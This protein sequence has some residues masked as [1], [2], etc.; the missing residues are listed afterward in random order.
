[1][2]SPSQ[3]PPRPIWS[4]I[5]AYPRAPSRVGEPPCREFHPLCLPS[6]LPLVG[7]QPSHRSQLRESKQGYI[8]REGRTV[9]QCRLCKRCT[10]L[11]E[12]SFQPP[13]KSEKVAHSTHF[14]SMI[15]WPLLLVSSMMSFSSSGSKTCGSESLRAPTNKGCERRVT[16]DYSR[17]WPLLLLSLRGLC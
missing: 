1:M 17:C 12:P 3:V 5:L 14:S 2:L 10:A 6:P 13:D 8:P 7:E 11:P 9:L 4:A 16:R 15:V